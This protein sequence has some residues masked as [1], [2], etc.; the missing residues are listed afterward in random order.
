[1][2]KFHN[3]RLYPNMYTTY[4]TIDEVK[5][6]DFLGHL[7]TQNRTGDTYDVY[8]VIKINKRSITVRACR[9][10]GVENLS[11][12]SAY[13]ALFMRDESSKKTVVQ[14]ATSGQLWRGGQLMGLLNGAD[15]NGIVSVPLG[16]V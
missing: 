14:L 7:N 16:R 6:G 9:L 11:N 13:N 2:F 5:P 10:V 15:D 4:P 8:E 12:G 1:M 3:T